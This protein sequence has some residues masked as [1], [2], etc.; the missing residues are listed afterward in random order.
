MKRQPRLLINQ[1]GL[2]FYFAEFES[3]GEALSF[4]NDLPSAEIL[5][6]ECFQIYEGAIVSIIS[7][8]KIE[9][10]QSL[11]MGTV[12]VSYVQILMGK[13]GVSLAA[14]CTVCEAASAK[15]LMQLS[16]QARQEGF[17][18]V[19]IRLS[20]GRPGHH[21][22]LTSSEVLKLTPSSKVVVKSF[23]TKEPLKDFFS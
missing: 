12:D 4:A 7:Q 22:I 5:T 9:S 17:Q 13:T 6:V 16:V 10:L 19:E 15:D 1:E 20:K 2:N 23:P 11:F 18:I 8:N 21:M 14:F 3:Y